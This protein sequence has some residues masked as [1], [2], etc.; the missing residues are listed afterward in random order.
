MWMC[1]TPSGGLTTGLA[2]PVSGGE[3]DDPHLFQFT[4]IPREVGT[5]AGG[6]PKP[7]CD[8]AVGAYGPCIW[9]CVQV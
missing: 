8:R 7:H 9:Q 5:P 6:W 2:R 1:L 3:Y 4:G